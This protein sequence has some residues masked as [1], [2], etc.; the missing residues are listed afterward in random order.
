VVV[1]YAGIENGFVI[2]GVVLVLA[3]IA[4][5]IAVARTP[6]LRR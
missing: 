2:V 5:A 4:L 6:E 1:E 3:C